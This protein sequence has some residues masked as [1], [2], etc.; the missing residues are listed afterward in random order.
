MRD[1]S[2]A[3]KAITPLVKTAERLGKL[4][5][6]FLAGAASTATM[7]APFEAA[8]VGANELVG[9]QS[10][11]NMVGAAATDL[12]LGSG[13]GGLLHGI[14]AAGTRDP[15]LPSIFPGLDMSLPLPLMARQMRQMIDEG[16]FTTP[17][18]IGRAKENSARRLKMQ[19]SMNFLPVNPTLVRSLMMQCLMQRRLHLRASLIEFSEAT[20]KV[21]RMQLLLEFAG[22]LPG[23][24]RTLSPEFDWRTE[25]EEAGLPIGD[26]KATGFQE[27]GQ[28]FRQ[29]SFNRFT[30]KEGFDAAE[31]RAKD[32]ARSLD[33]LVTN[34]MEAVGD[35]SYLTREADDGMFIVAKKY[36]GEPRKAT[37]DDKWILFKT[38]KPEFFFPAQERFKN[39]QVTLAKWQPNSMLVDDAGPVYNTQKGF[40]Q[41]YPLHDYRALTQPGNVSKI[42]NS[43]LP[44][45]LVGKSNELVNRVGQAVGEY[46][47]PRIQQFKKSARA[48]RIVNA[49]K[50]AAD[51]ADST[52]S[53][54][55][56]GKVKLD[57]GRD[58]VFNT[59][60]GAKTQGLD[61]LIPLKQLTDAAGTKGVQEF[62]EKI[63][64]NQVPVS[65]LDHMMTAG[66]IS[67]D[68][69][70]F[71]KGLSAIDDW[72]TTTTNQVEAATGRTP[73]EINQNL[74]GLPRQWEGDTRIIIHNDAGQVVAHASGPNRKAAQSAARV[75][76]EKNPGW[77]IATKD[78]RPVEISEKF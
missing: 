33:R 17:E 53:Q 19:E 67:P 65:Q 54:L 28:Y 41:Q 57:P 11:T 55:L 47:T 50:I 52:A 25:A 12:A 72:R 42:V 29:V 4:K 34:N 73:S 74:Y 69:V 36:A 16:K 1:G 24:R 7:L 22:S 38:D 59:L 71:A 45:N 43:L 31:K 58:L 78:G 56:Y 48:N 46:L 10:L 9:D 75:L 70:K 60:T 27:Q 18:S 13:I 14:S 20:L 35:G 15:K 30:T 49:A 64:R 51:S 5:S 8:R 2:G 40:L 77:R 61:G 68:T 26:E 32:A 3:A 37:P 39:L 62:A 63:W 6:P 66:E 44:Q 23:L 76:V 21:N